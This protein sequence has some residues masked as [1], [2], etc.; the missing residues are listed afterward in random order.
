M[1]KKRTKKIKSSQ[2]GFLNEQEVQI[3]ENQIRNNSAVIN[4]YIHVI[5]LLVNRERCPKDANTLVRLRT[6]LS[7]AISENDTFRKVLW[8]HSQCAES[9]FSNEGDLR[10]AAFIV[11]QIKIRKQ[12]IISKMARK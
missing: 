12:A 6:R 2:N 10:A 7:V 9:F 5:D 11:N 1:K 4:H 8:R 3:L